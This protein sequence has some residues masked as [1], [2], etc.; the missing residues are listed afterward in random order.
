MPPSLVSQDK[1][2]EVD[3]E[4]NPLPQHVIQA[5]QEYMNYVILVEAFTQLDL[6]RQTMDAKPRINE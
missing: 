3:A 6:W 1:L 5:A 4:G 2:A